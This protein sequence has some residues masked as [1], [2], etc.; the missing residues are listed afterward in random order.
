MAV[1]DYLER[2]L[3]QGSFQVGQITVSPGYIII[4]REDQSA[5]GLREYTDPHDALEIARYDEAGK[6]R[7]LKTA[8]NL[9]RGWRLTLRDAR[10]TL[11]ALDF[12]YPAALATIEA[13]SRGALPIIPLRETLARQTGMYAVVKKIT[14]E[15]VGEVIQGLCRGEPKC[16][17]AILWAGEAATAPEGGQQSLLCAE[18]CN[19]FVAEGRKVVKKESVPAA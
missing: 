19:L 10:E 12:L 11:M 7:P 18:A 1:I 5:E 17:R 2:I 16:L 14:D 13:S 4:H 6:Y 15:Q 9:R 3:R 8:A